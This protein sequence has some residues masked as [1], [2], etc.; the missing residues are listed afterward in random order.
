M[1]RFR[2]LLARA[3]ALQGVPFAE[4]AEAHGIA[5]TDE[6]AKRKGLTGRISQACLG[7]PESPDEEPDIQDYRIEL[8]A[9]PVSVGL[10][11]QENVKIRTVTPA[12]VRTQV[13]PESSVFR[14]MRTVLFMPVVKPDKADPGPWHFRSPFIWMPSVADERQIQADYEAVRALVLAGTPDLVSSAEPPEGQ[15]TYLIANTAGRDA[16]DL[17]NYGTEAQPVLGKRR[18]WMLRKAFMQSL[19]EEHVRYRAP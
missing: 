19:V 8:K 11:V 12:H 18:A 3:D 4:L 14:K 15:G 10:K 2:D 1:R 5:W 17:T 13:W 9:F 6:A 16:S 7:V